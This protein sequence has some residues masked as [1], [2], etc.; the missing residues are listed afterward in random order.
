M[1]ADIWGPFGVR[2]ESNWR[3]F[4][5]RMGSVWGPFEVHLG[6]MFKSDGDSGLRPPRD[7][8][9]RPLGPILAPLLDPMLAP[10]WH[11][12]GGRRAS[13]G[14]LGRFWSDLKAIFSPFLINMEHKMRRRGWIFE[15]PAKTCLFLMVLKVPNI[16]FG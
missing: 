8:I 10:C 13:S 6:P 11:H 5:V 15:K 14:V 7:K 2:L 3:P 9:S 12:V 16:A 1:R 4:G